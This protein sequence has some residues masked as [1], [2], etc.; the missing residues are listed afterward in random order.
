MN[1]PDEISRDEKLYRVIKRSKP[2]WLIDNN[3]VTPALFKDPEGISVDR[4]GGRDESDVILCIENS[5][6]GR[7]KAI[8]R[9]DSKICFE[10]GAK[11]KADP[12]DDNEYH[13]LIF[14][15]MNDENHRNVQALQL[16][17]SCKLIHHFENVKW[18]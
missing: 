11:L 9:I 7:A 4:D 15:D 8:G 3:T 6:G 17:D 5:F 2:E 16:A 1:L 12:L 13:A 10:L 18:V 14:L